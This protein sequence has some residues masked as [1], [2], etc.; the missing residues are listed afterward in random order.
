MG[1]FIFSLIILGFLWI[2]S[3]YA[4]A[5][6]LDGIID[7]P[8]DKCIWTFDGLT[9]AS[10]FKKVSGQTEAAEQESLKETVQDLRNV[11]MRNATTSPLVADYIKKHPVYVSLTTSPARVDKIINVLKTLDLSVI[12]EIIV[13]LPERFGRDGSTYT[14]PDELAHFPKVKI[15][16]PA[17]D[18]GPATKLVPAVEYVKQKENNGLV[19]TIDDDHGYPKTMLS[20]LISAAA[21]NPGAVVGGSGQRLTFW[22]LKKASVFDANLKYTGK[23][24]Y[25]DVRLTPVD[26][27]EG[28]GAIAYPSELVDT[29]LIRRWSAMSKEA[30]TSDD[31]VISMSLAVHSVPRFRFHSPYYSLGE[32]IPF[33]YG[34]GADALHRGAGLD[35]PMLAMH[36]NKSKYEVTYEEVL[37]DLGCRP[38]LSDDFISLFSCN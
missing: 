14:I 27:I 13:A 3:P 23:K 5:G 21:V 25:D 26:V 34:T 30:K 9:Y 18:I 20:E 32:I 36:F 37:R 4:R 19:V 7:E 33:H 6:I 38:S 24:P 12:E 17:F 2:G 28:F 11:K 15:L 1:K 16:R 31:M 8:I 22:N 29:D 10:R 35:K